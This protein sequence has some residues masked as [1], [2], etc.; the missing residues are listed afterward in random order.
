M[1]RV[2]KYI[3]K[4][5]ERRF[6]LAMELNDVCYKIDNYC[7][8][9]GVNVTESCE[10]SVLTDVT[11]Y[12]EPWNAIINTKQAIEKALRGENEYDRP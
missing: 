10:N 2:P 5:L 4:L 12:Y 1:K 7:E 9:V 11:I 8:K 6:K 3:L